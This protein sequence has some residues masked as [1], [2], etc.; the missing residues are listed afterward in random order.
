MQVVDAHGR[1]RGMVT[2]A[3]LVS[4]EAGGNRR[5]RWLGLVADYLRGRDPQWGRMGP[6]APPATS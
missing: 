3:D 6:A 1:L 2:E 5:R 4:K